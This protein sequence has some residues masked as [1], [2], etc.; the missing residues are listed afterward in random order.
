MATD[1]TVASNCPYVCYPTLASID[2]KIKISDTC[3]EYKCLPPTCDVN[4]K[5]EY[6]ASNVVGDLPCYNCKPICNPVQCLQSPCNVDSECAKKLGATCQENYCNGCN[7]EYYLGRERV[8]TVTEECKVCDSTTNACVGG[9]KVN[10]TNG[11]DICT[12]CKCPPVPCDIACSNG[13]VTDANGCEICE[14]LPCP[15]CLLICPQGYA[16]PANSICPGCSCLPAPCNKTVIDPSVCKEVCPYG[17]EIVDDCP[18]CKCKQCTEPACPTLDCPSGYKYD[19]I[20]CRTC[21]CNP[22]CPLYKCLSDC[23]ETGYGVDTNSG[24]PGCGCNCKVLE[25]FA[26][27]EFYVIDENGCQT[28]ECIKDYTNCPKITCALY[29]DYYKLDVNKCPICQCDDPVICNQRTCDNICLYGKVIGPDGCET[30]ECKFCEQ[31]TCE[32]ICLNGFIKDTN[33]G[34]EKCICNPDPPVCSNVDVVADTCNLLCEFG[35]YVDEYGCKYCKCVEEKP[36]DCG[37]YDVT[38]VQKKLCPDGKTESYMTNQCY[39]DVNN[40]VCYYIDVTC[41]VGLVYK[42]VSPTITAEDIKRLVIALTG[43]DEADV[44]VEEK[45]DRT[46]I[47]WIKKDGFPAGKNENTHLHIQY[48]PTTYKIIKLEIFLIFFYQF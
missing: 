34:C 38:T 36:C 3:G 48:V 30:C 15:Q 1:A 25:C 24:C 22:I 4:S 11:C 43:V 33:T 16:Q 19:N 44:Y 28:C 17:F 8:C 40:N 42:P 14:C 45:D 39:R 41:P 5:C 23:P 29:C 6:V 21:E 35:F 18:I 27:C 31:P 32:R 46:F 20:G 12:E 26:A 9:Y 47:I 37:P 13:Y 2:D 10:H 7:A